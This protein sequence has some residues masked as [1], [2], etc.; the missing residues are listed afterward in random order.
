MTLRYMKKAESSLIRTEARKKKLPG[1]QNGWMPGRRRA[2]RDKEKK[3][4]AA[5]KPALP[6]ARTL[7]VAGMPAV[8]KPSEKNPGEKSGESRGCKS[9]GG[10]PEKCYVEI[11]DYQNGRR[12]C[13]KNPENGRG[14]FLPESRLARKAKRNGKPSGSQHTKNPGVGQRQCCRE[15]WRR[16][17]NIIPESR[18]LPASSTKPDIPEMSCG[19]YS[20]KPKKDPENCR[21][22]G[23]SILRKADS[24]AKPNRME[25][26]STSI[27]PKIGEFGSV[28]VARMPGSVHVAGKSAPRHGRHSG[29]RE[30]ASA[31]YQTG[32]AR[33]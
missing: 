8:S 2:V 24:R 3:Q 5:G 33:R 10:L 18:E 12:K 7:H 32:A 26:R 28:H 29:K 25:S 13:R 19:L 16:V 31:V 20:G 1:S 15:S 11:G 21:G 30:T 27:I 23:V 17:T 6:D 22:A 14:R 4:E 9:A